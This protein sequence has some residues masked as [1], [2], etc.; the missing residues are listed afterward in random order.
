V[1]NEKPKKYAKKVNSPK[2]VCENCG[3]VANEKKYLC[4]PTK[5]KQA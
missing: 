1:H 5:L 2:Y 4:D 3:R